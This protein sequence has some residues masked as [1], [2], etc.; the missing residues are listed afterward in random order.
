MMGIKR[1]IPYGAVDCYRYVAIGLLA[2][3]P[4]A[5]YS[6]ARLMQP[7]EDVLLAEL[8]PLW[9]E[10]AL[11][12]EAEDAVEAKSAQ[13]YVQQPLSRQA[14]AIH[15]RAKHS[16]A[17]NS[18][19][20]KNYDQAQPQTE[21][22]KVKAVPLKAFSIASLL[23][24]AQRGNAE[25]QYQLGMRYQYGD[26]VR[27]D[28]NKAN[29][30]LAKAAAS[31]NARSQHALS[32]FYQQYATNTEG[33]KKALLWEKKAADHGSADAQYAL[34]VMFK[35]GRLVRKNEA[36]AKRWLTMAAQQGHLPAQLVL[37]E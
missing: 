12:N 10:N 28:I 11:A 5:S 31:G 19:K 9:L 18:M 7:V 24:T 23:E 17:A 26:G 34:G 3:L 21:L 14:F 13:A 16:I 8:A 22:Q 32:M 6:E 35:N 25:S 33:A 29:Q 2:V 27:M 20:A 15:S 4:L 37:E 30:W 36:E 1:M